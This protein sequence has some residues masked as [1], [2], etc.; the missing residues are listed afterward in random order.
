MCDRKTFK[1][2]L[3]ELKIFKDI[4]KFEVKGV[5]CILSL[6][7]CVPQIWCILLSI[8]NAQRETVT[9]TTTTTIY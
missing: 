2:Y 7:K 5:N 6:N 3:V 1:I 4:I 9:T 8:S